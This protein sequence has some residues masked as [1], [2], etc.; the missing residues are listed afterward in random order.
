MPDL[1]LGLPEAVSPFPQNGPEKARCTPGAQLSD[2]LV[3]GVQA[4]GVCCP[5]WK[6]EN[7]PPALGSQH[8]GLCHKAG[9]LA[10]GC[11]VPLHTASFSAQSVG[12]GG[13]HRSCWEGT[14]REAATPSFSRPPSAGK[15]PGWD[16]LPQG[17]MDLPCGHRVWKVTITPELI[18]EPCPPP[19]Q[20]HCPSEGTTVLAPCC[21]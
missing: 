4:S 12:P 7:Q 21:S 1:L 8:T 17:L 19:Q 3:A 20:P 16:M 5:Q 10:R 11:P 2:V 18:L 6:Q 13:G 15:A 14:R 9:G